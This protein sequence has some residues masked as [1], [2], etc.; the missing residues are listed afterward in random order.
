MAGEFQSQVN[1]D[2]RTGNDPVDFRNGCM[3]IQAAIKSTLLNSAAQ[4]K[5]IRIRWREP[6]SLTPTPRVAVFD[7]WFNRR[8]VELE[9]TRERVLASYESVGNPQLL[10]TIN[11]LAERLTRDNPPN[12]EYYYA[13][14]CKFCPAYIELA[15]DPDGPINT[16]AFEAREF[17]EVC[18]KCH[19]DGTYQT[20]MI[21]KCNR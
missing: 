5:E 13:V 8:L 20:D 18:P 4:P 6:T 17:E 2:L 1:R 3:A 21:V 7:V 11:D 10:R 14:A 12:I 16:I 19:A 15:H 9:V